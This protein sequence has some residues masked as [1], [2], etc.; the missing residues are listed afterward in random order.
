MHSQTNIPHTNK[1]LNY[2][3]DS[4]MNLLGSLPTITRLQKIVKLAKHLEKPVVSLHNGYF[5]CVSAANDT[6]LCKY[7]CILFKETKTYTNATDP[8]STKCLQ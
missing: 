3:E 2:P 8:T 6:E 4:P 1:R 5:L 7:R